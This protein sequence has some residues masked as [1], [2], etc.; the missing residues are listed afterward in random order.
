MRYMF[1]L[2]DDENKFHALSEADQMRIV[3]EHM[4]YSEALKQAGAMVEGAPL[5]HTR[6]AR[7][8]RG[9]RVENGPYTDSK[10]QLGGYYV[11]EAKDLDA[12][13]DWAAK[14]PAASYG[15]IEVRPVWNIE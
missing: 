13:L 2:Y 7:R 14:C 9:G 5:D 15:K 11:I 6:Q 10:E 1:M 4:A 8:V 3:S 12:A